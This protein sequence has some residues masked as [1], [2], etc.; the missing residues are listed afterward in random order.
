MQ[1]SDQPGLGTFEQ[2]E[3]VLF[4]RKKRGKIIGID[5]GTTSVKVLEFSMSGRSL[6]AERY[7]FEPLT[8]GVIIDHKIKDVGEVA[9]SLSRAMK[10]S[11]TKAKRGAVCVQSNN[12]I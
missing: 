1:I 10:K 9:E 8:P 6:V 11:G 5:I 2:G 7:G 12:V 3:S 4:S